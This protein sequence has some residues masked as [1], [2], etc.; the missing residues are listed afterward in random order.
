[1][2]KSE[3]NLTLCARYALATTAILLIKAYVE[4]YAGK[5]QKKKVACKIMVS[6][7][8]R[9]FEKYRCLSPSRRF[10]CSRQEFQANNTHCYDSHHAVVSI[11]SF[12]TLAGLW[13]QIHRYHDSGR[14]VY[15]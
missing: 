2:S 12:G 15:S 9:R 8:S 5:M 10:T 11:F 3:S 7:C 14:H 13:V 4:M 1:M 6:T